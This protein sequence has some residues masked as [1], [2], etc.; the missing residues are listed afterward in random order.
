[1]L[2][3]VPGMARFDYGL[4]PRAET[5]CKVKKSPVLGD[6]DGLMCLSGWCRGETVELLSDLLEAVSVGE[7]P[8]RALCER[9]GE[10]AD[11]ST[12]AYV[13]LNK[14][15]GACAT[16]CWPLTVDA[17]SVEHATHRLG[18]EFP[19]L[20]RQLALENRPM[21]A[22]ADL[23][24]ALWQKSESALLLWEMLGCKDLAQL[25]LLATDDQTRILLLA[26]TQ[27]FEPREI[28]LLRSALRPLCAFDRTL[29]SGMGARPP[30]GAATPTADPGPDDLSARELEVV[31]LLAKGLLARSIAARMDVSTRT[32]HKHLGNIYRKLDAH[33][34]LLAVQRA[35]AL[36]LIPIDSNE[37]DT[38]GR[39]ASSPGMHR[40]VRTRRSSR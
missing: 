34:R 14:T 23:E 20:V 5:D 28:H 8:Q 29:C 17:A 2:D 3:V 35:R 32:V 37:T 10:A 22:S 30:L 7:S 38:A 18:H 11:A 21:F 39:N 6:W 31:G 12:A 13:L 25:P 26:R 19:S 40:H 36:G 33:D 1:M 27:D 15:A 4:P 9:V 24:P 16:T